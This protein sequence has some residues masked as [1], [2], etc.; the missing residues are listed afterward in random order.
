M[1]LGAP[2]LKFVSDIFLNQQPQSYQCPPSATDLL[3]F[4]IILCYPYVSAIVQLVTLR[5][6]LILHS[7]HTFLAVA[8]LI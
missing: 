6:I 1:H 2:F 7:C 3:N 8:F 4:L 5:L